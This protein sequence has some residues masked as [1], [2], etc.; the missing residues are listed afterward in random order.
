MRVYRPSVLLLSTL[1][2][3]LGI[4]LLVR[5]AIAGGGIGLLFGALFV[6]AGAGRLWLLRRRV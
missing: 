6:A 4:A 1:M 2:V 5:T 3:A